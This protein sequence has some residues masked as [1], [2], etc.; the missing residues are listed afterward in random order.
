MKRRTHKRVTYHTRGRYWGKRC[1]DYCAGCICCEAW[2]F[3]DETGRFPTFDEAHAI[4]EEIN[5]ALKERL[6]AAI[7]SSVGADDK[8]LSPAGLL[9]GVRE[10]M[11]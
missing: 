8:V 3:Y 7:A 11:K 5:N 9:R 2:K 1:P 4:C 6:C 10:A